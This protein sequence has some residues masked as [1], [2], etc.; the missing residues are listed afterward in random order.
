LPPAAGEDLDGPKTVEEK[1]A[2]VSKVRLLRQFSYGVIAYVVAT[3]LVVLLP[4]FVSSA[5]GEEAVRVVLV[6]QNVVLWVFMAGLA[7]IF[8]CVWPGVPHDACGVVMHIPKRACISA[9]C[10]PSAVLNVCR[11]H[12]FSLRHVLGRQ[13]RVFVTGVVM[14]LLPLYCTAA[15][16]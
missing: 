16:T 15:L 2:K 10:A 7:W 12:A 13:R 14:M 11:Q 6:M 5:P 8:R 9:G 1:V 4:I 3:A